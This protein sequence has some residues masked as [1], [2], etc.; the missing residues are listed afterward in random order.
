MLEVAR[1]KGCNLNRAGSCY[2]GECKRCGSSTGT[3]FVITKNYWYCNRSGEGGDVIDLLMHVDNCDF[4]TAVTWLAQRA[5]LPPP[6]WNNLTPEEIAAKEAEIEEQRIVEEMLTEATHYYHKQLVNNYPD[7]LDHLINKRGLSREIID[8]LQIGFCPPKQVDHESTKLKKYERSD[9]FKHFLSNAKFGRKFKGKLLKSGLFNRGCYETFR[10]RIMVPF[11]KY[12]KVMYICGRATDYCPVDQWNCH[13]DAQTG[14][15]LYKRTSDGKVCRMD[16]NGKLYS[17]EKNDEGND[18]RNYLDENGNEYNSDDFRPDYVRFKKLRVYREDDPDT[19]HISKFIRNDT[20]LGEDR[21]RGA[22]QI[23]ICEGLFDWVSLTQHGFTAISPVTINIKDIEIE[24]CRRLVK[25]ADLVP[26]IFDNEE[27]KEGSI[28]GAGEEGAIRVAGA[29]EKDNIK[30]CIPM[31]SRPPGLEKVDVNDFFL[32]HSHDDMQALIDQTPPFFQ[33]L[34]GKIPGDYLEAEPYLGENIYPILSYLK[35]AMQEYHIKN[36]ARRVG[37]AKSALREDFNSFAKDSKG[38]NKTEDA[39]Q[40]SSTAK[41]KIEYCTYFDSVVDMVYDDEGKLCYMVLE[42]GKL[43]Y[44]HSHEKSG[45][46]YVPPTEDKFDWIVPRGPEVIRHFQNDT[47]QKLYHDLIEHNKT[48]SEQSNKNLYKLFAV[49]TLHTYLYMQADYSPYLWLY[50]DTERGKSRTC[51]G[52]IWAAWRGFMVRHCNGAQFVRWAEEDKASIF[53]DMKDLMK[54][55][56]KNEWEDIMAGRF[57]SGGVVM[58]I[59]FPDRGAYE[60]RKIYHIYGPTLIATNELLDDAQGTRSVEIITPLSNKLFPLKIKKQFP[61][62]LELRERGTAFRARHM[63]KLLPAAPKWLPNRLGDIM[64]PLHQ[65]VKLVNPKDDQWFRDLVDLF[66]E[67]RKGSRFDSKDA[68]V[69]EGVMQ[70]KNDLAKVKDRDF[71]HHWKT[72]RII[73]KG[74]TQ[75]LMTA[76]GIGRVAKKLGFELGTD[77][78]SRGIFWNEE[79]AKNL[80]QVFGIAYDTVSE[81]NK[82]P[83]PQPRS[84]TTEASSMGEKNYEDSDDVDD[85]G[86][87]GYLDT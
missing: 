36:I 11:W 25:G 65:I 61:I 50:G 56:V 45:V 3:S 84:A 87:T 52:M 8:E 73:N 57:E 37:I 70:C 40:Q 77:G 75:F 43:V 20:F 64:E 17:K 63:N 47:D 1:Q 58:R 42:N 51:E 83:V 72:K 13:V 44:K 19:H 16:E 59:M 23:I 71:L 30:T 69:V 80:C 60:E 68:R 5:G 54:M 6:S 15:I 12:G 48:V 27:P 2:Q 9:L 31:L 29:L 35:P 41:V 14:Y 85:S 39:N 22:E 33:K 66:N 53:L 10:G 4:P 24:K 7:V 46:K 81:E 49:W 62:F 28:R 74:K 79:L 76:R 32:Q 55:A 38:I 26:I 18:L 34:L 78:S 82:I 21:V 86:I 67:A